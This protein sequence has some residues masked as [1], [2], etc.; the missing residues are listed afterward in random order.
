MNLIERIVEPERLLLVWQAP[1]LDADRTR[2]LVAAIEPDGRGA[3]RLRYLTETEDFRAAQ[4][5]GFQGYPAFPLTRAV[6]EQDVL[7]VLMR[8]VPPRSRADFAA[9]LADQALSERCELSDLALLAYSGARL[10]S[11]DFALLHPFEGAPVP[12]ELV[13]EVAGFRH[14][15]E[16]L[17]A[18]P[19]AGMPVELRA[20]PD[21]RLD[22]DAVQVLL[23]GEVIG[24]VNRVQAATF[25]RWLET[26]KVEAVI[27]HVNGPAFRP[28]VT[29]F[30][31]ILPLPGSAD[32]NRAA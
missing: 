7:A 4:E 27:H 6:H 3:V 20:E 19:E 17:S 32:V 11:D 2:R 31:R 8:R 5:Q 26:A 22:P 14:Y 16:Q 1:A 23:H 9:F 18:P 15:G 21:N 10:P 29:L 28:M 12:C 13:T 30:V 25:R 24:Y